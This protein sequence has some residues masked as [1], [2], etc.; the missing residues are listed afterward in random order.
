ML[1]FF[2]ETSFC[3]EASTCHHGSPNSFTVNVM[4]KYA[5]MDYCG[6]V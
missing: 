5:N 2:C 6:P 1:R 4:E 3:F